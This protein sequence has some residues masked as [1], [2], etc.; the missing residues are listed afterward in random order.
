MAENQ[1]IP[2]VRPVDSFLGWDQLILLVTPFPVMFVA[3][4]AYIFGADSD[5]RDAIEGYYIWPAVL[6]TVASFAVVPIALALAMFFVIGRNLFLKRFKRLVLY[7]LVLIVLPVAMRGFDVDYLRFLLQ[8]RKFNSLVAERGPLM[9]EHSAYCFIFDR[10]VDNFY[11]GSANF[12]P[13]EKLIL[14][15]SEDA[16]G[17]S[18][19]IESFSSRGECPDV[20]TMRNVRPLKGRYYLADT[21]ER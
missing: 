2:T 16:V 17:A 15:A 3:T 12:P 10:V 21:F 9:V 7:C 5:A 8:E 19:R 20:G 6:L 18:P 11:I 1:L 13:Y 14:Y 4:V